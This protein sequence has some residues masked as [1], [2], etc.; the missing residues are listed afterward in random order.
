MVDDVL[1]WPGLGFVAVIVPDD[2]IDIVARANLQAITR[3]VEGWYFKPLQQTQ[4]VDVAA[5]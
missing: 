5:R 3:G 4:W 1:K 2:S